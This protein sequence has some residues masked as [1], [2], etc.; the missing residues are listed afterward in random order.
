MDV[1]DEISKRKVN[2]QLLVK[3]CSCLDAFARKD[4]CHQLI[5]RAC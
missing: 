1:L 4:L 3:R 5:L 2:S